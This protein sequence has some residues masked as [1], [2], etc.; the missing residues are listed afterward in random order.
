MVI[1][2]G[3]VIIALLWLLL[4]RL[5]L[6]FG[7]RPPDEFGLG[8]RDTAMGMA[9]T[10]VADDFT[11][12]YYNPAG[13]AFTVPGLSLDFG[14]KA[15][16]RSFSAPEEDAQ[17]FASLPVLGAVYNRE[18]A[19]SSGWLR[20]PALGF[21]VMPLAPDLQRQEDDNNPHSIRYNSQ[22][23]IP[24]YLGAA[25]KLTP[26][27]SIGAALAISFSGSFRA[28]AVATGLPLMSE[29]EG[30]SVDGPVQ[31][32]VAP[33]F[34]AKLG[35][36]KGWNLGLGYRSVQNV[37]VETSVSSRQELILGIPL[38]IQLLP[39]MKL[40]TVAG[41]A[42]R[43]IAVGTA[44]EGLSR[45]LFSADLVF[46]QWDEWQ[47]STGRRPD[48]EFRNRVVPRFGI[49][50]HLTQYLALQGGYYFEPSPV[51]EQRGDTSYVDN[52]QHVF[53]VGFS[54]SLDRFLRLRTVIAPAM[55][56][57]WL[58]ERTTRKAERS[59]PFFPGYEVSGTVISGGLLIRIHP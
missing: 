5:S 50:H 22:S 55:Q 27:F 33:Y 8:A 59:N 56:V 38:P 30:L 52:D 58:P 46:K 53:S 13:L 28:F 3:T 49:E 41:W 40:T 35:P 26:R 47:S 34:G 23:L 7:T 6:A 21:A 37:E 36:F 19:A 57:H 54:Y 10:A 20:L 18:Y 29:V 15:Y 48:P 2:I 31:F 45:W 14:Y 1:R 9:Y 39:P 32:D 43:E 12:V 17:D 11:A 24:V 51:P 16:G 4:P 42:P 44:Y 25:Y